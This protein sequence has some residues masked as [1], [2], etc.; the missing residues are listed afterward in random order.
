MLNGRT[1]SLYAYAQSLNFIVWR[2]EFPEISAL[3]KWNWMHESQQTKNKHK[4]KD[5]SPIPL[6]DYQILKHLKSVRL[7]SPSLY[8]IYFQPINRIKLDPIMFNDINEYTTHIYIW[9]SI[10]KTGMEKYFEWKNYL[11]FKIFQSKWNFL[12]DFGIIR[13]CLCAN[14]DLFMRFI[15]NSVGHEI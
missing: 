12:D 6:L 14:Y 4:K 11:K 1:A 5:I 10:C 9:P 13:R 3:K 8:R 15:V 2:V 7:N